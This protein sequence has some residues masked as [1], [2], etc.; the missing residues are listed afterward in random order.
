M[1]TKTVSTKAKTAVVGDEDLKT[2]AA[3]KALDRA[4]SSLANTLSRK[5]A[6]LPSGSYALDLSVAVRGDLVVAPDVE[7]NGSEGPT[8]KPADLLAA[9]FTG[10]DQ[11][12]ANEL[13]GRA[14]DALKRA[15][16]TGKGK[17]DLAQGEEL[18]ESTL[19]TFAK[20]R[21]RWRQSPSGTRAGATTGTPAVHV[22]GTLNGNAVSVEIDGGE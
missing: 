8:D 17:I 4:Q 21:N 2:L 14:M 1:A 16:Q 7:T 15:E 6:R 9:L 19:H 20:R 5:S 12:A 11:D 10:I 18:L 13:M 3:I 22:T